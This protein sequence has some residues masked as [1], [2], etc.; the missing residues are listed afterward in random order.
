[1]NNLF[2]KVNSNFSV[3]SLADLRKKY[4]H[5]VCYK[6]KFKFLKLKL[7][8]SKSLANRIMKRGSFLKTYKFI[9]FFFY[10]NIL[11]SKFNDI[12]ADSSFLFFYKKY[13]SFRDFDRVLFWK[14]STVDCMFSNKVKKLK[15]TKKINSNSIFITGKKRLILA[16]NFIKYLIILNCRRNIKKL[17]K[18]NYHILKPL[19]D[20]IT[21]NKNNNVMSVKYRIYKQKL[22]QMQN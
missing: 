12:K 21:K 14:L 4:N 5:S 11:R 1:M 7:L 6:N 8:P 15:K 3:S 2:K 13:F 9:K 22:L 20:F 10:K 16:T 19:F 18:T 17:E